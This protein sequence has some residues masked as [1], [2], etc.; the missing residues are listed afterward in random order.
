MYLTC[1]GIYF[2]KSEDFSTVCTVT[3][4]LKEGPT[5]TPG[6]VAQSL[7]QVYFQ[8]APRVEIPHL[9]G[10]PVPVFDHS[11]TEKN[12]SELLT[13]NMLVMHLYIEGKL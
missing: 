10:Q 11:H 6:Q 8:T 13:A 5:S 4:S 2:P 7:G 1:L 12:R 9:S 3:A